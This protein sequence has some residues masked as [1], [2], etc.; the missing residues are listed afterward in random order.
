MIMSISCGC[1][2]TLSFVN[3]A[4]HQTLVIIINTLV[5]CAVLSFDNFAKNFSG[6]QWVL[7]TV[8]LGGVFC[9]DIH[10]MGQE[11]FC[12]HRSVEHPLGMDRHMLAD[13]IGLGVA[14]TRKY[15]P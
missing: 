11:G 7:G 8:G 13:G 6:E 15:K 10:R 2:G 4:H 5:T 12:P 9:A 14:I 1:P 3:S